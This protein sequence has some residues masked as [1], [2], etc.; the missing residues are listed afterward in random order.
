MPLLPEELRRQVQDA[1]NS[2]PVVD[3]HTHLYPANFGPLCLWGIDEV[4][5]YHY[6][7]AELFRSAP[8]KPAQFWA[9]LP[10]YSHR[11]ETTS[12]VFK[13]SWPYE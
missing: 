9:P 11:R 4:V 6:L 13:Y 8:I 2:T 5:T 10:T 1:V 7:I 3:M 12:D